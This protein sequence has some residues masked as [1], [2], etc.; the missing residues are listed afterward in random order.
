M[1]ELKPKIAEADYDR[2]RDDRDWTAWKY[3]MWTEK[4]SLPTQT[5]EDRS[6]C[7]CGIEITSVS[8]PSHICTAH[9]GTGAK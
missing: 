2:W 9:R 4:L 8:I 7:F 5:R 3:R 6:R 1:S